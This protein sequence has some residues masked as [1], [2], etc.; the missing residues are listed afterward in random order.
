MKKQNTTEVK[1]SEINALAGKLFKSG[2]HKPRR[3]EIPARIPV[4]LVHDA[5]KEAYTRHEERKPKNALFIPLTKAQR[6]QNLMNERPI[7]TA[8]H[9]LP[10]SGYSMGQTKTI[11]AGSAPVSHH[12]GTHTYGG[13]WRG[14]ETHGNVRVYLTITQAYYADNIGGLLT[15]PVERINRNLQRVCWISRHAPKTKTSF[16]CELIHGYLVKDFHFFAE[17]K[18][19]AITYARRYVATMKAREISERLN[20][21]ALS[22]KDATTYVTY[23]DSL[24][25]GN[26]SDGTE[27]LANRLRVNLDIT[28]AVRADYLL[29]MSEKY[30][31]THFAKR[32][33]HAAKLRYAGLQ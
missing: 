25:G 22:R 18:T 27:A 29:E 31:L 3:N 2:N 16:A 12:D 14:S 20:T 28:G 17:S 1:Q 8:A 5:I 32:A 9:M 33:I 21:R 11:Y 26:C 7:S 6:I 24:N 23:Q 13:K 19:E 15:M 30:N 10:D 4:K